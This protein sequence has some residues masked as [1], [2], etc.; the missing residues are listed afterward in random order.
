MLHTL[1][2][3]PR[4]T[5][6]HHTLGLRKPLENLNEFW[7]LLDSW[8]EGQKDLL[9]SLFTGFE[10]SAK[11]RVGLPA[12]TCGHRTACYCTAYLEKL[13]LV[14]IALDDAFEQVLQQ[15][16]KSLGRG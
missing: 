4:H 6:A 16:P 14:G 10:V 8:L 3:L 7:A 5:E 13:L 9:D 15:Q 11:S 2:I 1:V 12:D